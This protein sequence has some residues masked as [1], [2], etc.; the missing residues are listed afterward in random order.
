MDMTMPEGYDAWKL[1]SP[2]E[3]ECDEDCAN[4]ADTDCD[5]HPEEEE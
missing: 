2:Y 3:G 1:A 5:C 4:C